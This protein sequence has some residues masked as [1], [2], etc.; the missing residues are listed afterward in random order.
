MKKKINLGTALSFMFIAMTVTF[1]LTMVLSSRLFERKVESV[2]EKE[3]MYEKVSDVDRIVRKNYYTDIDEEALRDGLSS[4][5]ARGLGD[6][7]TVYYSPREMTEYQ[8]QLDGRLIGI[9][10]DFVKSR[11]NSGYMQIYNVYTESP[12]DVQG[13]VSGDMITRINGVSVVNMSENDAREALMGVSGDTVNI[14]YLH[15]S[16]EVSADLTFRPFDYNRVSYSKEGDY[17]YIRISGFSSR[18]ASDLDYAVNNLASQEVKGYVIDV[19]DNSGKDYDSA[20]K[21]ADVL[22]PEGTTMNAI[23]KDG[24]TKVLYTSDKNSVSVPIVVVTDGNTGYSAEMFAVMLKDGCGAKTVGTRTMGKG[25]L[26]RMFRLPDGSGIELTVATFSPVSSPA[27]NGEGI[28]PDYER[29]LDGTVPFQ[30]LLPSD[31]SQIKR[32]LEVVARL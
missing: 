22:L 32:A 2:N 12:A 25:T 16:E 1:C 19:R 26:Q 7:D 20:A 27:Y 28:S 14:S 6:P 23:Y 13:M 29:E 30:T 3:A 21:A 31:D 5:Y 18:T 4:G 8:E 15:D 17:G 10:F 11:E 9:G 24:E